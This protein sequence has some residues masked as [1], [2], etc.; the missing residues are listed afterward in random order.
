MKI[1]HCIYSLNIGGAETLLV[2][3]LN[4]QASNHDVSL[5]IVN[6]SCSQIL[7][8]QIDSNVSIIR[9]KRKPGSLNPWSF[10]YLNYL[11]YTGAYDVVHLH[12]SSLSKVI[13]GAVQGKILYTIHCL[14]VDIK[15]LIKGGPIFAISDA[16]K[17]DLLLRG[18]ERIAPNRVVVV[19]NGVRVDAIMPK[20]SYKRSDRFSIV[21]V[22]RLNLDVKGQDILIQAIALLRDRGIDNLYVDFI[23]E[24]DSRSFLESLALQLNIS[25]Q[26][27]F[28]GLKGRDYIYQHLCDY[29]LMCHPSRS[30]GFGLT[31][32]EGMSAKLPVLVATGDGPYEVIAQGKYGYSFENGSVE[33]CAY[34]LQY[35]AEHYDE[36]LEK[37]EQSYEHVATNYSLRN[38]SVEYIKG[39]QKAINDRNN[40]VKV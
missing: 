15:N 4:Q 13:L 12:S 27:R 8:N 16:V 26:I 23:G 3:I 24:G 14:D 35:I 7:L 29:D 5:I 28:L 1:A 10:I 37:V 11:L 9:I 6:D 36:A 38:M 25:E 39:Y 20:V 2:D 22:A 19:P 17:R 31:V 33:S 30:E 32:A 18:R 21:N 34:M 40:V